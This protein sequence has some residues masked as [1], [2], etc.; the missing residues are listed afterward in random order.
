MRTECFNP[1]NGDRDNAPNV[2][3]L[4]TDGIPTV[5]VELLDDEVATIK[6]LG[7]R[8]LGVGVTNKVMLCCFTLLTAFRLASLIAGRG[9]HITFWGV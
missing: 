8:I 9:Q 1:A 7:I 3:V 5:D 4:I 2:A 6:S